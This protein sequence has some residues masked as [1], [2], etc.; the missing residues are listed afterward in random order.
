MANVEVQWAAKPIHWNAGLGLQGLKHARQ[1]AAAQNRC[2]QQHLLT[3]I[4]G[5]PLIEG[6]SCDNCYEV[7]LRSQSVI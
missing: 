5:M 6:V 4:R 3:K 7:A 1:T 2:S